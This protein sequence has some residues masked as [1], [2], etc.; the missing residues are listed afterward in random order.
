MQAKGS[1]KSWHQHQ[2]M[3]I[4]LH[5]FPTS[6]SLPA[7]RLTSGDNSPQVF[8]SGTQKSDKLLFKC[9]LNCWKDADIR[10]RKWEFLCIILQPLGVSLCYKSDWPP[11][12]SVPRPNLF[13]LSQFGWNCRNMPFLSFTFLPNPVA[14]V[15]LL[16]ET[17]KWGLVFKQP[18][19][20]S[21]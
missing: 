18:V 2:K 8:T 20:W 16:V 12:V 3:G 6:Q 21:A 1:E 11:S 4:P 7:L 10:I 19:F 13:W 5:Y 9:G 15:F 17:P 14:R